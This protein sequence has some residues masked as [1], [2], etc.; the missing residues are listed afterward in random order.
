M[1]DR[2]GDVIG[3]LPFWGKIEMFSRPLREVTTRRRFE[4]IAYVMPMDID[5]S[6]TLPFAHFP[7]TN[8]NGF[9]T[10]HSEVSLCSTPGREPATIMVNLKLH[11][12][13]GDFPITSQSVPLFTRET[14]E[15]HS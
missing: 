11:T 6:M 4:I 2:S 14:F 3:Q 9:F 15:K 8:N 12:Q 10:N 1:V 7:I 13:I 5:L